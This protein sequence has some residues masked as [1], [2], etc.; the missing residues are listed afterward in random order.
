MTQHLQLSALD[1]DEQNETKR[2]RMPLFS[3]EEPAV[4]TIQRAYE[5]KENHPVPTS[6]KQEKM[7]KQFF[8]IFSHTI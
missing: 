2:W 1:L 6:Q 4:P 7:N 5:Q 3:V 8:L